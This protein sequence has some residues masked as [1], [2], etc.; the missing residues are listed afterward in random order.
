MAQENSF[1]ITTI[2]PINTELLLRKAS[3]LCD[4][5]CALSLLRRTMEAYA[6]VGLEEAGA[7]LWGSSRELPGED[8][9]L[10]H[11]EGGVGGIVQAMADGVGREKV[12]VFW[13][14][15]ILYGT[16]QILT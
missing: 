16:Q 3:F 11:T 1:Q 8:A 14:S 12:V 7:V 6:G 5:R 9:A 10:D 15:L 4:L 2:T 13:S